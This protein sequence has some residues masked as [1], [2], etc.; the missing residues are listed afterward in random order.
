MTLITR[1]G[2]SKVCVHS[3]TRSIFFFFYCY[4]LFSNSLNQ[5]SS[6]GS[7]HWSDE[8][9][10][11]FSCSCS[12]SL[13]VR[14]HFLILFLLFASPF[15]NHRYPY[16]DES[17]PRESFLSLVDLGLTHHVHNSFGVTRSEFRRWSSAF[18]FLLL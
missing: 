9:V 6:R 17:S 14:V 2:A 4:F 8:G 1:Y 7:S 12:Y 16:Y 13:I 11:P 18:D 5:T 10:K 3:L 15:R